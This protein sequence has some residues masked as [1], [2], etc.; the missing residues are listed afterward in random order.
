LTIKEEQLD[1][2]RLLKTTADYYRL[3]VTQ[4]AKD[5]SSKTKKQTK[6]N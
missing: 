1:Y 2:F 4:P 3:L 6:T 5:L